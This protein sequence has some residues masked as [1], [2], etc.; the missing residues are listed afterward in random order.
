MLQAEIHDEYEG[1]NSENREDIIEGLR[2]ACLGLFG[3]DDCFFSMEE[4]EIDELKEEYDELVNGGKYD[5]IEAITKVYEDR[6][7]NFQILSDWFMSIWG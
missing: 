3:E 1:N 4:F 5:G 7:G 6:D 2:L